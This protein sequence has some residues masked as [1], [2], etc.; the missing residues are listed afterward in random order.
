MGA[1]YVE[2]SVGTGAEGEYESGRAPSQVAACL[3]GDV[4]RAEHCAEDYGGEQFREDAEQAG[5]GDEEVQGVPEEFACPAEVPL[6]VAVAYH[7]L[8]TDAE[9]ESEHIEHQIVHAGYGA[10]AQLHF[11]YS[12]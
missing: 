12:S 3:E 9:S 8:G 10:R 7:N 5:E 4:V 11:A 6:A 2:G 1:A